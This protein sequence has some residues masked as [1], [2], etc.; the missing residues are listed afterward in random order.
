MDGLRR[1]WIPRLDVQ[2]RPADPRLVDADQDV[3][4][5]D[6]RLRDL[7]QDEPRS[8]VGLD[9]GQHERPVSSGWP[10]RPRSGCR[11]D[12]PTGCRTDSPTG[13]RS[14][15]G[16]GSGSGG[17]NRVG[18]FRVE[19]LAP[20]LIEGED[21]RPVQVLQRQDAVPDERRERRLH[22]VEAGEDRPGDRPRWHLADRARREDREEVLQLLLALGRGTLAVAAVEQDE[23]AMLEVVDPALRDGLVV[24]PVDAWLDRPLARGVVVVAAG[25][26]AVGVGDLGPRDDMQVPHVV[27]RVA[28]VRRLPGRRARGRSRVEE[29]RAGVRR[30]CGRGEDE[31][32]DQGH[33]SQG[34]DHDDPAAVS[35]DERPLLVPVRPCR[36]SAPGATAAAR[37][38]AGAGRL[39]AR[40]RRRAGT[41]GRGRSG[42]RGRRRGRR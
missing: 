25:R 10:T 40:P 1:P 39:A 30:S 36:G 8:R 19:L 27:L 2:V 20:L 16:R 35:L 28:P 31:Q 23:R 41:Q 42:R 38:L 34:R 12:S 32:P 37:P 14:P 4:D 3:V 5:P 33:A 11:T 26:R 15:P 7:A 18:E 13:W 24:R 6:R 22:A 21:R 17:C 29:V 9:Q